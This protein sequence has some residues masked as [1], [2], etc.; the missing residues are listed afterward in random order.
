MDIYRT[1]HYD[2]YRVDKFDANFDDTISKAEY[3]KA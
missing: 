3:L 2:I 1:P